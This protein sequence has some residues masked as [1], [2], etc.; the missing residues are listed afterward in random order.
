MIIGIGIDQV[1][2]ARFTGWSHRTNLLRIFSGHELEYCSLVPAKT[3]E[4]LALRFAV[5]EAFFKAMQPL[6]RKTN[7]KIS[8]LTVCRAVSYTFDDYMTPV[9]KVN[10]QLLGLAIHQKSI[11]I[12]VSGTH[13]KLNA[14]VAVVLEKL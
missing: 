4:R 10:W 11:I 9:V 14:V 7:K 2:I 6:L 1:E 12:H 5:K 3:A 8:L 13:S